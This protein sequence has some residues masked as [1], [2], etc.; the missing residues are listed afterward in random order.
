[1]M[2]IR[3][4]VANHGAV[5]L[6]NDKILH[7]LVGQVSCI[8][9]RNRPLFRDTT[10]GILRHPAVDGAKLEQT[11]TID[12]WDLVPQRIRDR[13]EDARQGTLDV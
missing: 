1:L 12:A 8:E 7:H 9:S 2:A 10:V 3:S 5:L 13:L 4:P 11:V 6:P